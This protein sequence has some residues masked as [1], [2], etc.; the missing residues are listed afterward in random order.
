MDTPGG[1]TVEA[2]TTVTLAT[3]EKRAKSKTLA[4]L[5]VLQ[6]PILSSHKTTVMTKLGIKQTRKCEQF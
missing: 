3:K 1:T 6:T 2:A 5:F 4:L